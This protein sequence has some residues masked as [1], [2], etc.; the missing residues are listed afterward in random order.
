MQSVHVNAR[1]TCRPKIQSKQP[2]RLS[3][4]VGLRHLL[5]HGICMHW[6]ETEN[7]VGLRL[8]LLARH[9][10]IRVFVI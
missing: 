10:D 5:L 9:P 2:A 1:H 8:I 4:T 7:E 3:V 6:W